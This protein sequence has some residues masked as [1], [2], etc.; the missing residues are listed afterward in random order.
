MAVQLNGHPVQLQVDTAS[1][2]TLISQSLWETIGQPSLTSTSHVAQSASGDCVHITGELP[3]TIK[4][5]DKTASG[6]I[7]IANSSHNLLGLDFIEPLGFL[8]IPLN[9]IC[10]VV[11][12]SSPQNNTIDQTKDI[13]KR[14][15]PVFKNIL[16]RCTHAEATLSLKPSDQPVFQPKRP[17]LYAA[18]PLVDQEL[19]RLEEMKVIIPVTYSRWA[20]PIVVVKNDS[21]WLCADF[22][23]GL[24]TALEDHQYPSPT[25]DDLYT[26]L[27]GGTCF[28]KL[29]LTEAY[30]QVEVAATSRELLTINTHRGLF[31]FTRLPFGVKTAPAIFQQ[32]MDTMLTGMEGTA[33][34]LDDIII[35]GQSNQELME[36][37]SRVLTCIQD[38]GFQL[39]LEKCHF[40]LPSIKYLGFIF[41][42]Q[43]RR[44][45][46]ANVAAIQHLPPPSDVSSLRAFLGLVSYYGSFLLSLHQIKAPLN[47]LL[48][49][50]IKWSW[51]IDCQKSFDK[52]KSL[53]KSD[54]LL[55]HFDPNKKIV[56]AADA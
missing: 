14:F 17:V 6:T 7:Y 18:L 3:A 21:I 37:I 35:V 36:R 48:T 45:D 9:Q 32:I 2:I 25:P 33:A 50:D 55:T 51:P 16:G 40:Y 13:M 44:S 4:M 26:I 1:D 31:Q 11:S 38:F 22:S 27:N 42:R 24:N 19:K 53:I 52:I 49:K 39:W 20:A 46:P 34:Y 29:D 30:L 54:L 15:S 47:K 23:T 8:D 5:K 56:V 43:G 10:K 41:D 12:S 28:A